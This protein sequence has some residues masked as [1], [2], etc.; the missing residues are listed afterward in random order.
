MENKSSL[1]IESP[2]YIT[3]DE[4]LP[5]PVVW[6][7]IENSYDTGDE[8]PLVLYST[9][10]PRLLDKHTW[11]NMEICVGQ[12]LLKNKFPKIDGLR[13]PSKYCLE[14]APAKSPSMQLLNT[15]GH[16]VCCTEISTKPNSGT[17][18]VLDSL[19][20]RPSSHVVEHSCCLLRHSGCTMTFLNEKVQ[21][22]IGVGE[23]G[24]FALAFATDLCYG[25][26]PANQHYDQTTVCQHYVRCLESKAMVSF[27]KTTKRVPCRNL[28]KNTSGYF[29]YMQTTR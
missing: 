17:V 27:P 24:L 23:C 3:I 25:L 29:L 15:G 16:W 18:R 12:A 21:K 6:T 28:H 7:S 14:V 5:D 1:T 9:T 19:Y 2:P 20:N 8:V 22:Q 13:D 11:L 26:D 4:N 10:K